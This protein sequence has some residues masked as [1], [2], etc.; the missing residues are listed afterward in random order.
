M[1]TIGAAVRG[2]GSGHGAGAEYMGMA[3]RVWLVDAAIGAYGMANRI[4]P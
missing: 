2:Q 1:T 4:F 3:I